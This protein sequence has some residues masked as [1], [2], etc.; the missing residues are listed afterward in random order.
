[1]SRDSHQALSP[2]RCG[3]G[4][5]HGCLIIGLVA[6]LLKGMNGVHSAL[7]IHCSIET[8]SFYLFRLPLISGVLD[9][10]ITLTFLSLV[11]AAV[12]YW[13]RSEITLPPRRASAKPRAPRHLGSLSW[14]VRAARSAP[15]DRRHIGLL[16]LDDRSAPRRELHRRARRAAGTLHLPPSRRSDRGCVDWCRD[17]P[18]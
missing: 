8:F 15:L 14:S 9:T 1:M 18:R 11:A 13:L 3:V 5:R 12:M 7:E 10:L 2:R 16:L 6:D 4:I 17:R